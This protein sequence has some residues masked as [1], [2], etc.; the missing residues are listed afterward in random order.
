MLLYQETGSI[1]NVVVS[2][3]IRKSIVFADLIHQKPESFHRMGHFLRKTA[4][5]FRVST[6]FAADAGTS[7]KWKNIHVLSKQIRNFYKVFLVSGFYF[8]HSFKVHRIFDFSDG[9]HK[10]A[11]AAL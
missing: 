6:D 4:G 9:L 11:P 1:S 2:V 8:H 3:I 5:R 10:D 7:S